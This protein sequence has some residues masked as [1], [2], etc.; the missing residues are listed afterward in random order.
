MNML[1]MRNPSQEPQQPFTYIDISSVEA[2]SKQ[3]VCTKQLLGKDAPSRARKVVNANDVIVAT[4]RPNLN[5][6]AMVPESL[7]NQICST[8]FC[9]L[10]SGADLN[11]AYLFFF[12]RTS[13]FIQSLSDLVKG[14]LYPAVTDNQ[15]KAQLISLAPHAEQKRI[16]TIL[17]EQM[18]AVEKARAAAEARLDAARAL[19]VAYLRIV[20]ENVEEKGWR[21]VRLGEICS[22]IRGVS[23]D[24]GEARS[25][26]SPGFLPIL[27]AGNISHVVDLVNNLI[28][29]PQT[30]I[31]ETQLIQ[32]GDILICMS[33]GS[34]RV[35]GKT[36]KLKDDWKGSVGAFCGII[37]SHEAPTANYL[38]F[39]FRSNGYL[40]WRDS[41]ARGAN[42]QN[43]RFSEFEKL[44][45]PLPPTI[46]EQEQIVSIL[47]EQMA[48]VEKIVQTVQQ[49]LETINAVPAALLRR[50]FMGGLSNG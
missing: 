7:D 11:P 48:A 43:L 5:A 22:F 35:V 23:F 36:A 15:V 45:V 13:E 28:W 6:V 27:R 25:T 38:S 3:I 17:N 37:R 10:R 20:F 8:G 31:S 19:P 16:V 18:A 50:A 24:N 30:K 49:E 46:A 32:K 1:S 44:N 12:V 26:A 41:Q 42:I 47:T 9:V 34:P 4:T 33:S 39:W 29:V 14:A 40:E 21:W 2:K